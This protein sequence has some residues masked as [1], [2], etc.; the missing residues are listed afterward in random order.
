MPHMLLIPDET[1]TRMAEYLESLRNGRASAGKLLGDKLDGIQLATL[2]EAKFLDALINTKPPQI[3]VESAMAGDSSDWNLT[4][5]GILGDLSI[6]V[7]VTVF[8]NGHH[9]APIPHAGPFTGTLFYTPVA[10]LRNGRAHT[11]AD[12]AKATLADGRLN[13]K[14]YY[15]LYE[16]RLMPVFQE[17]N[18]SAAA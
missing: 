7:P 5:L 18:A 11:P 6:A 4:E 17:V 15:Q 12:W 2:T 3:C 16:R 8:D 14:G 10:L 1:R 13:P 9:T